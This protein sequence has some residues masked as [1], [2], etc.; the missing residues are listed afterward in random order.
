MH[1]S[2]VRAAQRQKMFARARGCCEYCR[3]QARFS[4]QSF[5]AEHIIPRVA[6]GT[7]A[8]DN[9]ALSCLGCNSHKYTKT[10]ARDPETGRRVRLFHPRRQKWSRHVAWSEDCIRII[11]RTSSGRATVEALHLNRAELVALRRILYVAGEHP[12]PER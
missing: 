4:T 7:T 1:N 6:G 2:R 9:L 11:G 5:A 12:P 3:S 8:L 10:Y